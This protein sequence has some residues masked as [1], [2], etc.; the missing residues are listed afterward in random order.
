M[1]DS[2]ALPTQRPPQ[3]YVLIDQD[4]AWSPSLVLRLPATSFGQFMSEMLRQYPEAMTTAIR[5]YGEALRDTGD[6]PKPADPVDSLDTALGALRQTHRRYRP[7][8]KRGA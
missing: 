2:S 3:T 1:A 8:I 5:E 6:Q 7:C 4:V